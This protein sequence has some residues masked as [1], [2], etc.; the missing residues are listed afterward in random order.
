MKLRKDRVKD[1]KLKIYKLNDF[2]TNHVISVL[3]SLP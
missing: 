3:E 1:G 2:E